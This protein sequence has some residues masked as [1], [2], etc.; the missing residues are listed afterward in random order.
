M[1]YQ[2]LKKYGKVKTNEPLAKHTAFKIGGPADFFVIVDSTEK[3]TLLLQFLDGE[4]TPYVI[5]GGGSNMLVS[6][7]GFRGVVINVRSSKFEVRS[8]TMIF[9]A[10]VSTVQVAQES[11]KA[12]FT[13]FEWGVGVPGTI[14]GA[15]RGNA[16]AMGGEMKDSIQ[17]VEVYQDGEVVEYDHEACQFDYRDSV[18]KHEGDII[19]RVFLQLKK[20]SPDMQGMKKAIE[21]LQY[22]NKTQPQ[23]YA[24]TGCI[25][26]NPDVQKNKEALLKHFGEDDDRVQ[27]FIRVGKIS[28]GW[29]V[30]QAGMKGDRVG[31][32]EV[33]ERHG[34]FIVN[35]GGATA[36]DVLVLVEK[37][38]ERVYTTYGINLEEEIQII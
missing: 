33:S 24:S 21:H 2:E 11:I 32:A 19:L 20:G 7:D 22:R 27:Q 35:L 12:G 16:G 9:D 3:F 17:K 13:G 23:G 30:E 38:K 28:A 29:L 14:G 18:F 25:F 10:G 6:D 1:I 36:D 4:G 31:E 8:D 5:L 34:N 15:V 37:I 26:K